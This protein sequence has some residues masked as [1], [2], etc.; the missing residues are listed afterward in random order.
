MVF[1]SMVFL[2]IFLPV[3]CVGYFIIPSR[4]W[5][6]VFLTISSLFFYAWGEPVYVLLMVFSILMNYS[7]GRGIGNKDT[8]QVQE[9]NNSK[10]NNTVK[11]RRTFFLVLGII[12]NLGLLPLL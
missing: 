8:F 11:R 1:S 12:L 9:S 4:T 3:V 2:F 6:N 5:K 10:I 7:V